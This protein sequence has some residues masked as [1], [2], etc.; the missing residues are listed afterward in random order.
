MIGPGDGS[1]TCVYGGVG[2]GWKKGDGVYTCI[3][4]SDM[5]SQFF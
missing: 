3:C 5:R 4:Y 2:G 1:E